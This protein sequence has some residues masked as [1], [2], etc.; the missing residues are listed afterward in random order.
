MGLV[1]V[2]EGV[3]RKLT[4]MQRGLQKRDEMAIN[5]LAVEQTKTNKPFVLADAELIDELVWM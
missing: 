4:A 2:S 3:N 5:A 1:G